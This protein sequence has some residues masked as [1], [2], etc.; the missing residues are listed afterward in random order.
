MFS[1]D[2][3]TGTLVAIGVQIVVIIVFMVRTANRA[4]TAYEAAI[5]ARRVADDAHDKIAAVTGLLALHREQVARE[6]VD[7]DALREMKNDL[8]DSINHLSDR[9]DEALGRKH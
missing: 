5:E 8:M 4:Q 3:N 2:L 1:W 7:K 9:I 6:F